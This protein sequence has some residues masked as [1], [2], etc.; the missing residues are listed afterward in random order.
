MPRATDLESTSIELLNSSAIPNWNTGPND[1]PSIPVMTVNVENHWRCHEYVAV[2]GVFEEEERLWLSRETERVHEKKMQDTKGQYSLWADTV[3]CGLQYWLRWYLTV[4][5]TK[6]TG[7]RIIK[8][9][10]EA[11]EAFISSY[12]LT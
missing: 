8:P 3:G 6:S 9:T 11:L 7:C 12:E 1:E 5:D 2:T 4:S 10:Q